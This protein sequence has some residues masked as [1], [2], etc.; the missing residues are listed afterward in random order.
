MPI[1]NNNEEVGAECQAQE[2]LCTGSFQPPDAEKATRE[3]GL[4]KRL[5]SF[6]CSTGAGDASVGPGEPA[7]GKPL[8]V[9][10]TLMDKLSEGQIV[11]L[12]SGGPKMTVKSI[13]GPDA[14]C[15]WF[16]GEKCSEKS[17]PSTSLI[18][19]QIESLSEKQLEDIVRNS[20]K[21]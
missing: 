8:R 14:V 21:G 9:T 4:L 6:A 17:F 19:T 13:D 2:L 16:S 1:R 20:E 3:W 15:I 10:I 12:K 7:F 11:E 18:P 5:Y